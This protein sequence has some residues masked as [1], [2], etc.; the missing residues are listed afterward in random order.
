[1]RDF[2]PVFPREEASLGIYVHVPFCR[3]RCHYCAFSTS[4]Y[5]VSAV[6]RYITAVKREIELWSREPSLQELLSD[7]G[8]DTLYFGGGTPS[9]LEPRQI[10]ELLEACQQVFPFAR[11][12]EITLEINPATA[13]AS[14]VRGMRDAGLNRASLGIQSFD[15]TELAAM[16]RPH[17]VEDALRTFDDLRRAGFDDISLDLIGGFPGQTRESAR[18][19][20]RAAID[21]GP[22]HVSVYLLEVKEGSRLDA[23][24][25]S[26][27]ILAPDEDL[28]ADIYLDVCSSLAEAGYAQ[29]EISNFA[30]EG[31][32]SKHN[33]KYWRDRPYLGLG[34]AAHGMTGRARYANAADVAAY[35]RNVNEDRLPAGTFMDFTPD[36]RFREALIM[37]LRLVEGLDLV[38]LGERYRVDARAFVLETIGDLESAGLFVLSRD[39]LALTARGRLLSNIVFTRW[40]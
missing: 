9:L 36:I 19:S 15:D 23:M 37:G 31:H 39:H 10:Q 4:P 5:D 11:N 32:R 24:I 18:R 25:R 6:E 12:P 2:S 40:V 33:L 27:Q 17:T 1:M 7:F 28:A 13:D 14:K 3:T 20:L 21:L 30:P 29:Y 8:A 34:P 16:G 22:E 35:E 38:K 26:G